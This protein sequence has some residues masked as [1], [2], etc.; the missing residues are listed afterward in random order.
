MK[1]RRRLRL[2]HRHT[3]RALEIKLRRNR[4]LAMKLKI[5]KIGV[6]EMGDIEFVEKSSENVDDLEDIK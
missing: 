2:T 1:A 6:F 4:N 5:I 3:Y